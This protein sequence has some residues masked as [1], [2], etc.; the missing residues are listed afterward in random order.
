[1]LF[2]EGNMI[3][4]TGKLASN[5]S[6]FLKK[7]KE[8]D[9]ANQVNKDERMTRKI[10]EDF[11]EVKFS[12][13][14]FASRI[15][16]N[17]RMLTNYEKNLNEVQFIDQKLDEIEEFLAN[18]NQASAESVIRESTYNNSAP[19]KVLF[20]TTDNL[21]D[22]VEVT[23][24]YIE[25]RYSELDRE[26]KKIE[27]ASQNM[28]SLYSQNSSGSDSIGTIDPQDPLM[29]TTTVNKTRVMDL[30]SH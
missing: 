11:S 22:Q 9:S 17:N 14:Q 2:K 10:L 16:N 27:V 7:I 24:N 12:N 29:N 18:N 6:Q 20:P 8:N 13:K 21:S 23:R 3:I 19:L 4:N 28:L 25:Q 15:K 30:I 26:F 5:S 1:M